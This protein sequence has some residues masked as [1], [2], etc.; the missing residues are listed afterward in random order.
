MTSSITT[1][2]P[3]HHHWDRRLCRSLSILRFSGSCSLAQN[4]D[5]GVP[6]IILDATTTLEEDFVCFW[7]QVDRVG[8][9]RMAIKGEGN[10]FPVVQLKDIRSRSRW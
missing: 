5:I 1:C 2:S 3:S 8:S 6:S 10:E 9:P 4:I 7:R